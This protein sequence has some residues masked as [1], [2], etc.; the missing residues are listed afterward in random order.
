MTLS[1]QPSEICN[2]HCYGGTFAWDGMY[3]YF[4]NNGR[5]SNS[6]DYVVYNSD[7]VYQV[8]YEAS[9]GGGVNSTYFDWSV[10]RYATHSGYGTRSG[11]TTYS[12]G[13]TTSADDSQ[14]YGPVS[15]AHSF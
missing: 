12:Y 5:G 6:D 15:S 4:P 11:G 14:C 10:G 3:Y 1:Q 2:T 7:G 13:T 9:G 8:M